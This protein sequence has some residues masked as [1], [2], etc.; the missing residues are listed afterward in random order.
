MAGSFH[1]ANGSDPAAKAGRMRG[2]QRRPW[3]LA[4][5][6]AAV[7]I[8]GLAGG[9]A[10][11]ANHQPQS[12]PKLAA[13]STPT[14]A[15]VSV[16]PSAVAALPRTAAQSPVT[17]SA[18]VYRLQQLLPAGRT[19]AFAG[20][21]QD[22]VT[23]QVYLDRG[24]GPGMVRLE[25]TTQS[26]DG[27]DCATS[28]GIVVTCEHLAD[29]DTAI[30]Q[31]VPSNC[32]QSL[33]VVVDHPGGARVLLTVATCLAWNGT[34]NPPSAP[35]LTQDEAVRIA[36]DPG[37]GL[38]MNAALVAAAQQKFPNSRRSPDVPGKSLTLPPGQG[39]SMGA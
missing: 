30:V 32:V 7:V 29:G 3:F 34:T 21:G 10:V 35:A 23:G 31:H 28:D 8:A 11:G 37:W 33:Q 38:T 25:V 36:D 1:Q 15:P 24:Q 22:G 26:A 13:A 12:A 6:C 4:G 19:S 16:G 17:P 20:S 39:S 9:L 14:W 18:V 27:P 2:R 5:A